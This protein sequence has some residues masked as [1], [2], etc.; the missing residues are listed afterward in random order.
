MEIGVVATKSELS[1]EVGSNGHCK[2]LMMGYNLQKFL[3][4]FSSGDPPN[5]QL[6]FKSK[7]E[8]WESG[9]DGNESDAYT[10]EPPATT[11]RG[12]EL[13]MGLVVSRNG[14]HISAG[15]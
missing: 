12:G 5:T 7:E 1:E 6:D 9:S 3:G 8:S 10:W 11:Y 13:T 15:L 2:L 14:M 4:R